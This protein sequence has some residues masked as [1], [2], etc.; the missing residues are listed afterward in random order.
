[1]SADLNKTATPPLAQE[2]G[3]YAEVPVPPSLRGIFAC[4]WM[5]VLPAD[6]VGRP[7]LVVPD[8]SIDLQWIDGVVRVAG[9]DRQAHA[10]ALRPGA[11]VLGLRFRPGAAAAWLGIDMSALADRRVAL[12]D[13]WGARAAACLAADSPSQFLHRVAA[14]SQPAANLA[15]DGAMAEAFRLLQSGMAPEDSPLRWLSERLQQPERTL[16]RRFVKHFGYGPQTLARLLRYQRF[17]QLARAEPST[18]L[19]QLAAEAGYADQ[20]HLARESRRL[21]GR[22]PSALPRDQAST[23]LTFGQRDA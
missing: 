17:L 10:E 8:G 5:H 1:M 3:R 18:P 11:Q 19:A 15:P 22:P 23:T 13:L 12:R 20:P 7:L 6:G 9:P 2:V 4:Q 14:L 21:A 16:R